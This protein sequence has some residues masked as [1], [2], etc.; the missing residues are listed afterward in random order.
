MSQDRFMSLERPDEDPTP[1]I[2]QSV[3]DCSG[4][5]PGTVRHKLRALARLGWVIRRDNADLI[6]TAKATR[7]LAPVAEAALSDPATVVAGC[8]EAMPN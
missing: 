3:A 1:N 2:I 8:N 6:A 7:D 5:P 4:I